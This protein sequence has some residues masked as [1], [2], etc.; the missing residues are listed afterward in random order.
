MIT[1]YTD[2]AVSKN[3]QEGAYGGFGFICVETGVTHSAPVFHATNQICEL[4]GVIS[5]CKYA[6]SLLNNN[7]EDSFPPETA[8]IRSDSAYIINC[9]R[10]GWYKTWQANGWKNSKKEPVANKELWEELIPYFT[11]PLF[12]FTKVVGHSGDKYNERADELANKGKKIAKNIIDIEEGKEQLN[13][14]Q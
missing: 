8:E 11:N 14:E 12:N 7:N 13:N 4:C 3:G 2:G 10:Q 6:E 9:Y 5:A 1:V